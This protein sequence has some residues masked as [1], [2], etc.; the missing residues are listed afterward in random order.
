M[1]QKL[2]IVLGLALPGLI[3]E[4]AVAAEQLA[5]T[6]QWIP[7]EAVIAL[8]ISQPKALLDLAFDPRLTTAVTSLP[9]YQALASQPQ[10]RQ[11]LGV[12]GYLEGRLG[13]DRKTG[14][15]KLLGGGVTLAVNP[16]GTILLFVDAEDGQ[17]LEQLHE[18]LLEFARNQAEK[19]GQPQRVASAEYRGMT[20]W[21]FGGGEA[22]AIVGNRLVVANKPEGLK[23]VLDLRAKPEGRSLASLPAYQ[24]AKKAARSDAV[25]T[26]FVNLETLKLVPGVQKALTG[27][28]NPLTSL[29]L[30]GIT[31]AVRQSKWLAMGLEVEGETLKLEAAVDGSLSDLSGPAAFALPG[32]PDK[33]AFPNLSVPRLIAG[34]SFYRNLH[35][36]Y[37]A[38]DELFPERTSELIFFENMMGIFFSGRDLTEEVLA[39]TEPEIRFVVAEQQYDPAVG[40]PRVQIPAFAAIFRLRNPQQFSEVVEEAWQ[41]AVGLISFTRGQRALPKLIIDRVFHGDV[42]FTIAYFSSTAVKDRANLDSRF[43]FRPALA[44]L[45]DYMILSSA[46]G[47]TRDLIDA[48]NNEIAESVKPLAEVHSMV[49]IDGVQLASILASNREHLVRQNM[50][51]EGKTQEQ[52]ES[53]I[54]ILLAVMEY[55]SQLE[56]KVGTRDGQAQ[57]S[58][59]LRLN[60]PPE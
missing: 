29:L 23:A 5:A 27:Q 51:N 48:L 41:A 54:D 4:T 18:I 38:K 60:V 40:T 59:Q 11:F 3:L 12:I 7:K 14:L 31:E 30:A 28:Q 15:G 49:Q 45:G 58:L 52:A 43:N 42:K 56:L 8:E 10:F 37:A 33:G 35:G 53:Q 55:L 17:M 44:M 13:T 20:S 24:A 39:Q 19:Q 22:H 46:E 57:A 50:I 21:T 36:F 1:F 2:I 16:N 34:M 32:Q 25:A 47:L 9:V 6:S 26:V